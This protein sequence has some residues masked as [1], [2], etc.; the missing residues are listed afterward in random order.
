M[1][2]FTRRAFLIAPAVGTVAARLTL[3]ADEKPAILGG[4]PVRKMKY[5][6][7]PIFDQKEEQALLTALRSGKWFRGNGK[8][9]ARFEE[10]YAKVTGAK[11][12]LATANG[13]SALFTSLNAVDV[14]PGDEVLIPPYTFVAT[15]NVVL[16]QHALP[17]WVDVD[18]E[19][20]QMDARKVQAAVT[21]RTRA[22]I[23][24]H[25]GG[26]PA[27]LDAILAIA[28]KRNLRIIEDAC[29]AHLAAWRG[30]NVGNWGDTGCFSFQASKNLN[31]GEG[32]AIITNNET[33][34]D[35]C[36]SFHNQGRKRKGGGDDEF[37]YSSPGNNLRLTEFQAAVL[38]AQMTRLEEQSKTREQNAQY[39]NNMLK[40][41]PG[42][43]P[44]RSYDGCTRHNQH[45]YVFRYDQEKFAGMT[46]PR[47]LK[48]LTAEGIPARGGYTPLNKVEFLKR[49]M[50][51]RIYRNLYPK[52]RLAQLEQIEC[53]GNEKLCR[54]AV[55]FSH[56]VLMAPRSEMELIVA[57]VRKVQ[58]HAAEIAKT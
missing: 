49:V 4:K 27:D 28:K 2:D 41:I 58:A 16:L 45:T 1:G 35:R 50:Q 39:L 8:E 52:E 14:G 32:G 47:L 3:L 48:A 18:P 56:N 23:P 31:S 51:S 42:V 37:S 34:M 12:C 5:P 13:T 6:G 33:L 11:F 30:R 25:Y 55:V 46:K 19:T 21:E 57:A 24:V 20:C 44:Q 9:V 17:V 54:E 7:W 26:N 43:M 29:Q 15:L 22:I 38:L 10:A 36:Y 53:P 40:E